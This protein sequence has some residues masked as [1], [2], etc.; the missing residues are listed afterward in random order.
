[1]IIQWNY[2]HF[3]GYETPRFHM[4]VSIASFR[5]RTRDQKFVFKLIRKGPHY[6]N[7]SNMKNANMW[8]ILC[9]SGALADICLRV[10]IK[11]LVKPE[12]LP[13]SAGIFFLRQHGSLLTQT[14]SCY[15][16]QRSAAFA[17][18]KICRESGSTRFF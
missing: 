7:S 13:A 15:G 5:S 12:V 6:S 18:I 3:M 11:I 10:R 4:W 16:R 9:S 8:R 2:S 14:V 1:M 17:S